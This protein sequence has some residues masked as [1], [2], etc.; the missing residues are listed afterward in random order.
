M[1]IGYT[2]YKIKFNMVLKEVKWVHID[3]IWLNGL[4]RSQLEY[5]MEKSGHMIFKG[6][7]WLHNDKI[8]S[9]SL[10]TKSIRVHN[11]R[12]QAICC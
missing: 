5:T 10:E 8:R 6:V 9:K 11:D 7:N 3:K 2:M 12:N 1:Q 4:E